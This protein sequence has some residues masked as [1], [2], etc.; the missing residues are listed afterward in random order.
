MGK[1]RGLMVGKG[2]RAKDVEGL[3]M[4]K[5]LRMAKGLRMG[6]G[7][8]FRVAKGKRMEKGGKRPEV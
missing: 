7:R 4:G 1:G 8:M 2:G 5:G 6:K 3:R